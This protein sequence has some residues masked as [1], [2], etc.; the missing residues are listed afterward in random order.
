VIP[1]AIL[2]YAGPPYARQRPAPGGSAAVRD[3]VWGYLPE[4]V[5]GLIAAGCFVHV[6]DAERDRLDRELA[7]A[8]FDIVLDLSQDLAPA[9]RPPSRRRP[10]ANASRVQYGT[11][12]SAAL[13]VELAEAVA[14]W[15]HCC[16]YGHRYVPPEL[17]AELARPRGMQPLYALAIE[18]FAL[19]GPNVPAYLAQLRLLGCAVA[20]AIA[21]HFLTA[22]RSA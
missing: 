7:D 22:D 5:G 20:A 16:V 17:R 6:W 3:V 4:L 2:V 1:P 15:G 13:A 8:R 10:V 9:P 12:E 21:D 14:E 11:A 18:P 19:E